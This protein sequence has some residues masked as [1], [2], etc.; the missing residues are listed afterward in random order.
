MRILFE[1]GGGGMAGVAG[2]RL[3]IW[4]IW[5]KCGLWIPAFAGMTC[6]GCGGDVGG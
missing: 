5:A 2:A 3:A 6:W 4:F 1:G